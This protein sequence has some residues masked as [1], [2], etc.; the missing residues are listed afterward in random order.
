MFLGRTIEPKKTPTRKWEKIM[1]EKG[2]EYLWG[3][4]YP[5]IFGLVK[6]KDDNRLVR[7]VIQGMG[8]WIVIT[9]YS[10]HASNKYYKGTLLP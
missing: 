2:V 9:F 10:V 3:S 7:H 8:E 1:G 4:V 5:K 6:S